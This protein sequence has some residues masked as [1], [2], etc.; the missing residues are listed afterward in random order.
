MAQPVMA[1]AA[2]AFATATIGAM[3]V[4][5]IAIGRVLMRKLAPRDVGATP[6]PIDHMSVRRSRVREYTRDDVPPP[7]IR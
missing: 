3:A 6:A 5:A 7:P 1:R 4:G 2:G